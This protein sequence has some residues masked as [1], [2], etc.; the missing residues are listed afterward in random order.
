MCLCARAPR[1]GGDAGERAGTDRARDVGSSG[2]R[3]PPGPCG[4]PIIKKFLLRGMARRQTAVALLVV[5]H[6]L[7]EGTDAGCTT[8]SALCYADFVAPCP[9]CPGPYHR[10]RVLGPQTGPIYTGAVSREYCAQLCSDRKL[11]MAGL[12]G[13]QCFCGR[14]VNSTAKLLTG[15][16]TCGTVSVNALLCAPYLLPSRSRS[17]YVVLTHK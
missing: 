1:R 13:T 16:G 17:G 2:R 15:K 9:S 11:A 3:K 5:L 14:V 12:E 4:P 10:L 8:G 6:V 7:L